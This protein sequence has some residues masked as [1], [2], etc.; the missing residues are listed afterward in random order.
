MQISAAENYSNC[1]RLKFFRRL[2]IEDAMSRCPQ[3]SAEFTTEK[4]FL[5]AIHLFSGEITPTHAIV[6]VKLV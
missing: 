5:S 1:N 6:I 2:H 3:E 4:N